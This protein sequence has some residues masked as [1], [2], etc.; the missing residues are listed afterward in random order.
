[1]KGHARFADGSM[2]GGG[3]QA[4]EQITIPPEEAGGWRVEQE[5]IG[6][7]QLGRSSGALPCRLA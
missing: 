6:A 4:L 3:D 1:M 2:A 5:F 7:I